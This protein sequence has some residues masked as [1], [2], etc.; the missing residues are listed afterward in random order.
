[1]QKLKS[2]VLFILLL[3][4]W[5]QDAGS[6]SLEKWFPK[7]DWMKIG[8][9]YYPEQWPRKQWSRDFQNMSKQGFEFTH[10]AEFAW[11]NL[12]PEEGKFDFE[13]L[14]E[15]INLAAKNN[16]KVILC[17]PSAAPPIWLTEKYPEV[18]MQ[19]AEGV[20][21]VHGSRTH[22]SWSSMK[23]R[24]LVDKV[25]SALAKKYGQDKRIWGWQIDNEPSHYS[26]EYDYSPAARA[27]FIEWLR[28]K[29][30]SID[31]LNE[32]WGNAFWSIRYQT[33]EQIRI[34]NS[35][36]LPQLPSPHS[37]LD[38][39]RFSAAEC[40]DFV[41]AQA[42]TLRNFISK[43]QWVTTNYMGF[44]LP[45]D[46]FLNKDLDFIAT[47]SYPVAG[48]AVGFGPEGFRINDPAALGQPLDYFRSIKGITGVMELQ[49]GQVNWGRYNPQPLPG[50]VRLWLYQSF[51]SGAG[52]VCSYRY[53]QP[54]SGGEQYHYGM[55]GPDGVTPSVG[56]LEYQQTIKEIKELRKSV[57]PTSGLPERLKAIKT[58]IL[59]SRD[60][61][62]EMNFQKQT[63]QWNPTYHV[64]RY[65]E[66]IRSLQAPVDF[67]DESAD[68][69][70]YPFLVVPAYQLVDEDLNSKL[71]RYVEKG[72][73]LVLSCRYGQKDKDAHLWEAPFQA[74]LKKLAGLQVR[75]FDVLPDE[76]YGKVSCLGKNYEWNNWG[77]VLDP[78]PGTQVLAQYLDQFYKNAAAVCQRKQGKGTV[79][80]IGVDSESFRLE[81]EVLKQVY[82]KG[83]NRVVEELPSGLDVRYRDGLWVGLNFHSSETRTVPIPSNAKILLGEKDLK[84]CGVVIWTEKP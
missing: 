55:V 38:Y 10:L 44:H 2:S 24:E 13:W 21:Q 48:F 46:P 74:P 64:T 54:L 57:K 27:R 53:R 23:Y 34:P 5:M 60:N 59:Y 56:G 16:L 18:L 31:K 66:T 4:L 11:A 17:T 75:F 32:V 30:K 77:E 73:N 51:G 8:V 12:E 25:V 76:R 7:E 14:D 72:G 22:A 37:M 41:S 42:K 67:L 26:A 39:K 70:A 15:A 50:A 6:Q 29:Y 69:S 19:N 1:M 83:A 20:T 78:E 45:N 68:F 71:L 43:D 52:F 9:Y 33:F 81:T 40:A 80:Y 35:R 82:S 36:E 28:K 49:P 47:T 62:W 3:F 65:Y 58:G 61:T 63:H 79:T 84:P